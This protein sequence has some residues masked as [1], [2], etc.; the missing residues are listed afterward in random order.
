MT[1]TNSR[2]LALARAAEAMLRSL[3]GTQVTLRCA[4]AP[5]SDAGA[6]DLGLDAPAAADITVSPVLVR[7]AAKDAFE[8]LFAPASLATAL[9]GRPQTPEDSLRAVL[10]II[11]QGRTLRVRSVSTDN[12]A[13]A[14]YLYRVTAASS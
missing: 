8:L 13:G 4:I 9:A 14:A 2:G 1:D 11:H 5:A 10:A 3:G 7:R 12:F 6:R